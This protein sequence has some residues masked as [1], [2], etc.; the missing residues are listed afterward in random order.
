MLQEV[1]HS[2][3]YFRA[4][5]DEALAFAPSPLLGPAGLLLAGFLDQLINPS[6]PSALLAV[7]LVRIAPSSSST[8][9]FTHAW[10]RIKNR[11]K[12]GGNAPR[13]CLPRDL[14]R[15]RGKLFWDLTQILAFL[16]K[17]N[18]VFFRVVSAYSPSTT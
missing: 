7:L 4:L 14:A 1:Q 11:K 18:G 10:L 5:L 16:W 8:A 17:G 2:K 15:G 9:N 3:T 12:E 13:I 6:T